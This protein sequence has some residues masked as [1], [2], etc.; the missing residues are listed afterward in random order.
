MLFWNAKG[1]YEDPAFQVRGTPT[2]TPGFNTD[3]VFF[4][5]TPQT[6][7][8]N[9]ATNPSSL[10][11]I[12]PP[13][14]QW[15][16]AGNQY[17]YWSVKVGA[18]NTPV[19]VSTATAYTGSLICPGKFRLVVNAN[20]WTGGNT[21]DQEITAGVVWRF[22]DASK[23]QGTASV[24]LGGS[25]TIADRW[26]PSSQTE[27][28]A[29]I[30]GQAW[31]DQRYMLK[32]LTVSAAGD[33]LLFD[34][35]ATTD[36]L[37]ELSVSAVNGGTF[38]GASLSNTTVEAVSPGVA[39]VKRDWYDGVVDYTVPS[40]GGS[41]TNGD[42]VITVVSGT[43]ANE[44]IQFDG[45]SAYPIALMGPLVDVTVSLERAQEFPSIG[46]ARI[47]LKDATGAPE[48]RSAVFMAKISD[49]LV[50]QVSALASSITG[51]NN[52]TGLDTVALKADAISVGV[53]ITSPSASQST[54][55][56]LF[57]AAA[58]AMP[59]F[60]TLYTVGSGFDKGSARRD[61]LPLQWAG[62][63]GLVRPT[64]VFF[65]FT[66]GPLCGSFKEITGTVRLATLSAK[67]ECSS[68][69]DCSANE[70]AHPSQERAV[71][72]A[73]NDPTRFSTC[74]LTA[75]ITGFGTSQLA[76]KC[77]ECVPA[78][79]S[80][81][82]RASSECRPGQFCFVDDGVCTANPGGTYLCDP[83]AATFTGVCR[84]KSTQVLGQRC[85]TVLRG[86]VTSP[87]GAPGV[88]SATSDPV[89]LGA[90]F[91]GD[92]AQGGFAPG[93]GFCGE[94]RAYNETN[95]GLTY[96]AAPSVQFKIGG[97]MRT[98]LWEG[99]CVMGRCLE[100]NPGPGP[101]DTG[102]GKSCVNGRFVEAVTLDGTART[103]LFDARASAAATA[104][105][106]IALLLALQLCSM[107]NASN[108]HR[109]L[110]GE[111]PMGVME[112]LFAGLYRWMCCCKTPSPRAKIGPYARMAGV[113]APAAHSPTGGSTGSV[114][115]PLEGKG[116]EEWG[117][118]H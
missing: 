88:G 104:A 62:S 67:G 85:R 117:T 39:K 5:T 53:L 6:D 70:G 35:A 24:S 103:V 71:L 2:A 92:V 93:G 38:G 75:K 80:V 23:P 81:V 28:T 27:L 8:R 34:P 86:A 89:S 43:P 41:V 63:N 112:V 101:S 90:V 14:A 97:T 20:G 46:S 61:S 91:D 56:G 17:P 98:L 78:A 83:E 32:A 110:F 51:R 44:P 106:F 30:S 94:V 68:H 13:G 26:F 36:T 72:S 76:T 59:K 47:T 18:N 60:A 33:A 109:E 16:D 95:V 7:S 19:V 48:E 64:V 9:L 4:I 50:Y 113:T 54:G 22:F 40:P 114:V 65:R 12:L 99:A 73:N 21:L 105:A 29:K 42:V 1:S 25:V 57:V 107:Q 49:P 87:S 31:A 102:D 82:A 3:G 96:A 10:T 108:R 111:S 69:Y 84:N 55:P 79:S 118:R 52:N 66:R 58:P 115:N 15:G 116:A 37:V 74:Y 45:G 77:S 11:N 100:C